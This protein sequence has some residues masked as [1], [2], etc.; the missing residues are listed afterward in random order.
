LK[1]THLNKNKRKRKRSRRRGKKTEEKGRAGAFSPPLE[2]F[3]PL[4]EAAVREQ[5]HRHRPP[6]QHPQRSSPTS[7][8][9]PPPRQ[10]NYSSPSFILLPAFPPA[11]ITFVLHARGWGEIIPPVGFCYCWARLV[12]AQHCGF[13]SLGKVGSDPALMFCGPD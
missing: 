6:P 10:V 11:C 3:T 8:T 7:K 9:P 5:R 13:P 1:K 12:L 2:T 4:F